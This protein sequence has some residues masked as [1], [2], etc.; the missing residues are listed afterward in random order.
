MKGVFCYPSVNTLAL[1]LRDKMTSTVISDLFHTEE[2]SR[3]QNP[4]QRFHQL[5]FIQWVHPFINNFQQA[6][7]RL[8]SEFLHRHLT[9]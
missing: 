8:L 4:R 9:Q 2:P 3:L 7:A 5:G 1:T 6:V